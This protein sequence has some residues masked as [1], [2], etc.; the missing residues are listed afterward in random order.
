MSEPIL[1]ETPHAI[2]NQVSDKQTSACAFDKKQTSVCSPDKII[3]AMHKFAAS[4]TSGNKVTFK[5]AV[6]KVIEKQKILERTK[7]LLD[8]NSEL[9]VLNHPKFQSFVSSHGLSETLSFV[10]NNF[11]KPAGPRET[12]GLLSNV[13]IDTILGQIEKKIPTYYHIPYQMRDFAQQNS[14]LNNIDLAEIF[15]SGKR[16]FGVVFN[17]DYSSGPGIHWFCVFGEYKPESNQV[18]I[19]YFNSSGHEPLPEIQAWI[20]KI[21][22]ELRHKLKCD[23]TVKYSTGIEYQADNHSCG[24]YCIMYIWLRLEGMGHSWFTADTFNDKLVQKARFSIFA[25]TD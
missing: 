13:D 17:T 9:C 16:Y 18:I 12:F 22:M 19:E 23:V 15:K 2:V 7:S 20:R 3:D 11:F 4:D 25:K 8:C 10:K 6:K 1:H 5:S 21:E 14:K 24:V